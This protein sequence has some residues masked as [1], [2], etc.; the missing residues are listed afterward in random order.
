MQQAWHECRGGGT[1]PTGLSGTKTNKKHTENTLLHVFTAQSRYEEYSVQ[2]RIPLK[3][4]ATTRS[5]F[6]W[7]YNT[8][9]A[10]IRAERQHSMNPLQRDPAHLPLHCTRHK[11]MPHSAVFPHQQLLEGGVLCT[12]REPEHATGTAMLSQLRSPGAAT[13]AVLVEAVNPQSAQ[14][15]HNWCPTHH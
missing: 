7:N 10:N 1:H 6:R 12:I 5:D 11:T 14:P 15:G 13:E 8:Q 3:E 2:T 4:V 9:K